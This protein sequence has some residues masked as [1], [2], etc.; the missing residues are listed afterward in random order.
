MQCC[1]SKKPARVFFRC[2]DSVAIVVVLEKASVCLTLLLVEE[3]TPVTGLMI[4]DDRR[5]RSTAISFLCRSC[6]CCRR[7][8]SCKEAQLQQVLVP[9]MVATAGADDREREK[10]VL[11]MKAR[12]RRLSPPLS[13]IQAKKLVFERTHLPPPPPSDHLLRQHIGLYNE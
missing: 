1:G 8:W 13:L 9:S 6:F 12:A 10:Y 7:R 5:R 2:H 4:D 3:E 11:C